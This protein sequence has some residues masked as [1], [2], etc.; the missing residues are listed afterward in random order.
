MDGHSLGGALTQMGTA[1]YNDY[2]DKAYTYNSPGAKDLNSNVYEKEEYEALSEY[3]ENSDKS[4]FFHRKESNKEALQSVKELTGCKYLKSFSNLS[5]N[6][7]LIS[8][9][10]FDFLND[11]FKKDFNS[12]KFGCKLIG[13]ASYGCVNNTTTN[14]EVA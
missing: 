1:A 9:K 6:Q 10:Q 5:K 3:D 14:K 7:K 13:I 8:F 2:I 12:L 4:T 11:K